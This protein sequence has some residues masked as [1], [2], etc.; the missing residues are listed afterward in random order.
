MALTRL[1]DDLLQ[2]FRAQGAMVNQQLAVFDPLGTELSKPAAKRLVGKGVLIIT[3][4]LCYLLGLGA[5]AFA[6][7]LSRIYPFTIL[8]ELRYKAEYNK[9]GTMNIEMFNLAIYGLIALSAI[10]FFFLARA[11]RSIRLKNNILH[12]AGEHIKTLVGQHLKRKAEIDAINQRHFLELPSMHEG[13][14]LNPTINE[15]PNPGYDG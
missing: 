3:E 7:M 5:I 14:V 2:D 8:S 11:M 1:Q 10:L 15:I 9:L 4:I 6:V 12:F 13:I